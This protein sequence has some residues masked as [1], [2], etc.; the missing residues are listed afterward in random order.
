MR[1]YSSS[2]SGPALL[3]SS[4]RTANL[5]MMQTA[6]L[7]DALDLFRAEFHFHRDL[8]RKV[9]GSLRMV[10]SVMIFFFQCIDQRSNRRLICTFRVPKSWVFRMSAAPRSPKSP[11]SL[12]SPAWNGRP[13][14]RQATNQPW[15]AFWD[16]RG[17]SMRA[18]M[19]PFPSMEP[20]SRHV[21]HWQS[22]F[23]P[24]KPSYADDTVGDLVPR[25][26]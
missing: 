3:S 20:H 18:E 13:P 8:T 26:V 19:C 21:D 22:R 2:V 5:P 7:I 4:E 23:E 12:A 14:N 11:S 10:R 9:G 1:S 6:P 25:A 16:T 24:P 17:T 15:R